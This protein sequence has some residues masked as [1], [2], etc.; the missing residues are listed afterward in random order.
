MPWPD[1]LVL[2][3]VYNFHSLEDGIVPHAYRTRESIIAKGGKVV[4]ESA[5]EVPGYE[6][7]ALGLWKPDR[8][9]A[10]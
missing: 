8:N 7:T 4:E 2:V 3:T 1:S 9:P 6:V 10:A 5:R